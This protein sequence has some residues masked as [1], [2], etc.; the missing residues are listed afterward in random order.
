MGSSPGGG[1]VLNLSKLF[2]NTS[3][4]INSHSKYKYLSLKYLCQS[5][6]LTKCFGTQTALKSYFLL[7]KFDSSSQH[8]SGNG[9]SDALKG[10]TH[11]EPMQF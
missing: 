6:Y 4:T 7:V 10:A 11:N 8:C 9:Q 1:Q 3:Y 5:S 2:N